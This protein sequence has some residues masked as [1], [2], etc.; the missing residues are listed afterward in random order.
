MGRFSQAL[1]TWHDWGRLGP[2]T[3][4]EESEVPAVERMRRA[5]ETMA[6]ELERYRD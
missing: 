4:G 3:P 1:D 5:V 2:R 6:K